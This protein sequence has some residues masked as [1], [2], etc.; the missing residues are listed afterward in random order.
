MP[1]DHTAVNIAESLIDI[2]QS[3][4]LMEKD[5]VS[6]TTDNGAN[7]MSPASTLGCRD[8]HDLA[9]DLLQLSQMS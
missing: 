3:W 5:Q 6:I 2:R 8:Y 1:A 9:T 7:I 4:N